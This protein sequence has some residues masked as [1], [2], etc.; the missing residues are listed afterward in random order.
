MTTSS[1]EHST[2]GAGGKI[3]TLDRLSDILIPSA[4]VHRINPAE[5]ESLAFTSQATVADRGVLEPPKERV[6]GFPSGLHL[7]PA[8]IYE[9]SVE[10]KAPGKGNPGTAN[11]TA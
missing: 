9:T 1:C 3:L 8:A 6:P 7:V 4:D 5:V 10:R 2:A 11:G